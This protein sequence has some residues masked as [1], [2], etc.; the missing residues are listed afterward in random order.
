MDS[1]FFLCLLDGVCWDV[2]ETAN[3]AVIGTKSAEC[4]DGEEEADECDHKKAVT[5]AGLDVGF[6]LCGRDFADWVV[7]GFLTG[8]CGHAEWDG[9]YYDAV[10]ACLVSRDFE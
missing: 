4:E 6:D 10:D 2:Y 7:E 9:F 5:A 8:N 3:T 1:D